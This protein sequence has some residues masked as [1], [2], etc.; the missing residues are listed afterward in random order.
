MYIAFIIVENPAFRALFTMFSSTLAAWIPNNGDVLCSWIMKAYYN[1][2]VLLAEEIRYAKSNIYL[3]FDLWTLLNLIAFVAVV[4]HYINDDAHFRTIL[5]GLQQV[6]GS[7]AEEI[8]AEQ[9][10]Q[11]IQEY[12]I[13]KRLKYFVLDNA[14]SNDTCIEAIL[15]EIWPDLIKKKRKLWCIGHIIN[16]AA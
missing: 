16:I 5:I 15:N 13:E 14:T 3:S 2:K 1:W 4:A 12:G 10:V 9:V 8:I 6:I 11:V 7:H